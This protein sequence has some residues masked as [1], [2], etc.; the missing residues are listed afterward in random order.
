MSDGK[1]EGQTPGQGTGQ[2][3]QVEGG[4][5]VGSQEESGP[6]AGFPNNVRVVG[7][8]NFLSGPPGHFEVDRGIGL[9]DWLAGQAL[10]GLLANGDVDTSASGES[11]G[12]ANLSYSLADAM[13]E[14]RK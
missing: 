4:G 9:R 14:A 13:L 7:A 8:P 3:A 2:D 11:R 6:S 12:Y 5:Y 10:V 1:S